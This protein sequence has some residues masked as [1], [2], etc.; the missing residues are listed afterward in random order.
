MSQTEAAP[1]GRLQGGN[2]IGGGEARLL[3][4]A[5]LQRPGDA[6][7]AG[8]DL[9]ALLGVRFGPVPDGAEESYEGDWYHD[10]YLDRGVPER[11]HAGRELAAA[12]WC[13]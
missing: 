10:T 7:R 9:G 8:R 5:R 1:E 3:S 6:W 2:E 4:A 12:G 11:E 13:P